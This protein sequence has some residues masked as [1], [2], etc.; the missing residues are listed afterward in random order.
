MNLCTGVT[1]QVSWCEQWQRLNRGK[2]QTLKVTV[3]VLV[4]IWIVPEWEHKWL[5]RKI[6]VQRWY[7]LT[8]VGRSPGLP[9]RKCRVRGQVNDQCWKI[10]QK[11]SH[12]EVVMRSFVLFPFKFQYTT[13]DMILWNIFE[14]PFKR[15]VLL[16]WLLRR[17]SK[18]WKISDF[19]ILCRLI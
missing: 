10:E 9:W 7:K 8:R 4:N 3:E 13:K 1:R 2:Q 19:G 17:L 11:R 5:G 18:A 6:S 12:S 16:G 15:N 14:I